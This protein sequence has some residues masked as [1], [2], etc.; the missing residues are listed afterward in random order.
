MADT[1]DN[2]CCLICI[3]S[4]VNIITACVLAT[5]TI[6]TLFVTG[7]AKRGLIAFPIACTWQL[8]NSGI[9]KGYKTPFRRSGHI[10]LLMQQFP[11]Q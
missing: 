6:A 11:H 3:G 5:R 7:S 2:T 4:A 9:W 10:S 8:I 1:N